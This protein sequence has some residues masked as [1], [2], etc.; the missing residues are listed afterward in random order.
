VNGGLGS[1]SECGVSWVS[2]SVG[3]RMRGGVGARSALEHP[4]ARWVRRSAVGGGRSGSR[5]VGGAFDGPGG[6][7]CRGVYPS[8]IP[9]GVLVVSLVYP[10]VLESVTWCCD[11]DPQIF[12]SSDVWC[13]YDGISRVVRWVAG[14]FALGS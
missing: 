10:T 2:V 9:V 6:G 14:P 11:T 8:C 7:E 13:R 12:V 1:R 3:Q 5:T 4:R